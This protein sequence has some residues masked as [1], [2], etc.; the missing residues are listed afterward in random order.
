[1]LIKF[2]SGVG[3]KNLDAVSFLNGAAAPGRQR[4]QGYYTT[5]PALTAIFSD[6]RE[7]EEKSGVQRKMFQPIR[8]EPYVTSRPSWPIIVKSEQG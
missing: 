5:G 3:V 4:D 2:Y 1:M 7:E 8:N 6:W